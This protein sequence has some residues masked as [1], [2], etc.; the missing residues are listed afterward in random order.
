LATVIGL[1]VAI[2]QTNGALAEARR[3]NRLNLLFERRARRQDRESALE[4]KRALEIAERNSAYAQRQVEIASDTATRQLRAYVLAYPASA[5]VLD[6]VLESITISIQNLGLTPASD[7]SH[8][9]KALLIPRKDLAKLAQPLVFNEP[10]QPLSFT[11]HS[12]GE[13]YIYLKP[14]IRVGPAEFLLVQKRSHCLVVVG[15]VNYADTFNNPR[16]SEFCFELS[17]E[18][19]NALRIER[20]FGVPR[21]DEEVDWLRLPY[22]NEAS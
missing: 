9:G 16:F 2:W 22:H 7:C 8:G 15:R 4:Q 11:L 5:I 12:K 14:T 1:I 10:D 20:G 3:G 6:G 17:A 21:H 13:N 18:G 19:V